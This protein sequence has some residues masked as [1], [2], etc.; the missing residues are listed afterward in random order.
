MSFEQNGE[1]PILVPSSGIRVKFNM[2]K[3]GAELEFSTEEFKN[4]E[5]VVAVLEMGRKK[6]EEM[7]R[8]SIAQ[9][10]QRQQQAAYESE[11]LRRN[12]GIH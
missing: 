10:I 1:A 8:I 5:W 4:W 9:N 2:E 3:Q 7:A 6:A 12:L 11:A